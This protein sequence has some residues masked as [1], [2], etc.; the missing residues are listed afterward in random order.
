MINKIIEIFTKPYYSLSFLEQLSLAIMVIIAIVLLRFILN[1][2]FEIVDK[3]KYMINKIKHN[4]IKHKECEKC[5]YWKTMDC[6]NSSLCYNTK[7]KPYFK[8]KEE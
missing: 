1:F 8:N 6:P 7:N 2:I 4:K 3:I 5:K